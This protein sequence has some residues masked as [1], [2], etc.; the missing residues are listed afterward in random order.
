V[1]DDRAASPR[2]HGRLHGALRQQRD[3]LLDLPT[4]RR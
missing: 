1:M 3:R 4:P 2:R